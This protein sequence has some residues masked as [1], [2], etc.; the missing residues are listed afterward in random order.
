M[1][2]LVI[3]DLHNLLYILCVILSVSAVSVIQKS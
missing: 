1:A 2:P 3:K